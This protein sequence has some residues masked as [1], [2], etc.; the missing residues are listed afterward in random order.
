MKTILRNLLPESLRRRFRGSRYARDWNQLVD[1]WK[2]A[3]PKCRPAPAF[4]G[5]HRIVIFPSDINLIT[6]ALGDD[7]MITAAI[8]HFTRTLGEIEVEVLCAPASADLVRGKGFSPLPLPKA[9]QFPEFLLRHL[10]LEAHHAVVVLGADILDGYYNPTTSLWRLVAADI[11]ARCGVP[12][13]IL[14]ASFNANPAPGLK[15]VFEGL[16]PWVKLNIRDEI[17]LARLRAFASVDA[18]LVADSAFTMTPGRVDP[19]TGDWVAA[20]RAEGRMVIGMNVHPMLI[21]NADEADTRK[22]VD[23]AVSAIRAVSKDRAISWLMLPHDY[24][25]DRGDGRCLRPM[26]EALMSA[27]D[28]RTH[29]LEGEHRAADLKAMAGQLDGVVT[30]RMHLAIAALGMGVPTLSLTYQDK[31]EGL[32][33]HFGL[34]QSLLLAPSVF[35]SEAELVRGLT[36]FVG[37]IGPL[38]ETVA[39]KKPG[40]LALSEKNFDLG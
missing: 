21:K 32:Y 23:V 38:T 10:T 24:R 19:A 28:I 22:I 35:D 11:A 33:R 7:A 15:A 34:P 20:Q 4:S 8:E 37:N 5:I 27:G 6:G 12:V 1:S 40:V 36:E 13:T 3:I 26:H 16:D 39:A 29:Y 31:F 17:S 14:G 25:G 18:R 9:D 30:G 2:S